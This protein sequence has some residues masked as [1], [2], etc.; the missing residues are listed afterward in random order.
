[1]SAGMVAM[2]NNQLRRSSVVVIALV[3]AECTRPAMI[4]FQ[5]LQQSA[6]RLNAVSKWSET[7]KASQEGLGLAL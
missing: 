7:A 6:S 3:R 4:D 2:T 5:S 1:M